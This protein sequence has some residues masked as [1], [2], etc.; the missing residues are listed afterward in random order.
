[1]PAFLIKVF[2]GLAIHFATKYAAELVVKASIEALEKAAAKTT[3][4]VDDELVAKVK[5]D[6]AEIIKIIG[7]KV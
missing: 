3:T 2:K 7:G 1:M 4:L 5:A 6:Q